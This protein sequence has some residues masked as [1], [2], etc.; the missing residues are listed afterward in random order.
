LQGLWIQLSGQEAHQNLAG[1]WL[2]TGWEFSH[3]VFFVEKNGRKRMEPA[4]NA[5]MCFTS[6]ILGCDQQNLGIFFVGKSKNAWRI[7]RS[8]LSR[9]IHPLKMAGKGLETCISWFFHCDFANGL[10]F[11]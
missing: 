3:G 11:K 1:K 7:L 9:R 2:G 4:K 8:E 10:N 5:D 6:Q